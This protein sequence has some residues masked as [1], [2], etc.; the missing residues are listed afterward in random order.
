MQSAFSKFGG[1][2]SKGLYTNDVILFWKQFRPPPLLP[3]IMLSFNI[4]STPHDDVIYVKDNPKNAGKMMA[5]IHFV[6]HFINLNI[7]LLIHRYSYT[8][9][10]LNMEW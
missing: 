1:L 2:G 7:P 10:C 5:H 6:L 8:E 9:M 3:V 4:R